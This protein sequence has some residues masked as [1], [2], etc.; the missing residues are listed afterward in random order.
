MLMVSI[1][2][3]TLRDFT[4]GKL[5]SPLT[6]HQLSTLSGILLLG[7][8]ICFYA[9]R[10]PFVSSTQAWLAGLLWVS[11]TVA[12]EFLFFHYVGGHG[13]AELRA[14]YNMTE[15]RLWPLLLLWVLVAPVAF[16]RWR[17]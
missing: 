5:V 6:A 2:N 11:M 13:W 9:R 14:N 4:Y 17:R 12:F 10:W 7:G 8:V 1:L 15:G 16:Y 3:G